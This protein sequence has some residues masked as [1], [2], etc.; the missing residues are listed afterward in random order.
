MC[1]KECSPGQ[2]DCGIQSHKKKGSFSVDSI[3]IKGKGDSA[4]LEPSV[5]LGSVPAAAWEKFTSTA[6]NYDAWVTIFGLIGAGVE[7][8]ESFKK[9]ERLIGSIRLSTPTGKTGKS[10]WTE[11]SYESNVSVK[12]LWEWIE[13]GTGVLRGSGDGTRRSPTRYE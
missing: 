5:M 10:M 3:Y 1:L 6:R 9:L 4:F 13:G 2:S 8:P 12:L 7:D 11:F